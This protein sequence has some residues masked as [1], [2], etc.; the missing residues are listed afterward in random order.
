M[1]ETVR[2]FTDANTNQR[3][4][5]LL[6]QLGFDVETACEA[7]LAGKVRDAKLLIHAR[8]NNRIYVTFDKL[9]AEEGA[10][11]A[12]E[13][14]QNGGQII[15]I[16]G[17]AEQDKFRIIG[18]LLFHYPDWY[19]FLSTK[20]GISI[21]SDIRKQSYQNLTPKDYHQKYHPTDAKQFTQY[22]AERKKKQL[23]RKPRRRKRPPP[24][25]LSL[26]Y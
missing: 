24:E 22:L 20:N 15:Q 26:I 8:E 21:I 23:R 14:R 12:R 7:G 18:K 16:K 19:P 6:R 25:Q 1:R 3:V 13:L 5:E 9:R 11:V 4:V 2:L 10:E 17:G